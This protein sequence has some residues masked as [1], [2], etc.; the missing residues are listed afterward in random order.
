VVALNTP[1]DN[2][3]GSVGRLLPHLRARLS[4]TGEILV[5]GRT[6]SGYLGEAGRNPATVLATGDTGYFD[7]DGYLYVTGRLRERIITAYGRNVSPEWVEAELLAQPGVAQAAVAG[8]GQTGLRAVLVPSGPDPSA[9]ETAVAAANARLPDYAR[10]D[11]WVPAT[12][13]FTVASGQ[14]S[15]GG[16]PRR[17]VIEQRY[18]PQQRV[19]GT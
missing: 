4:E 15:A 12:A 3:P 6:F 19:A 2:R 14:A 16:S 18:F 13:P 10:V 5:Q 7:D 9:L 11:T 8:D 17:A 1:S